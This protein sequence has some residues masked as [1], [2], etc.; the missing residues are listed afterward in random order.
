MAL[1][2]NALPWEVAP[3]TSLALRAATRHLRHQI[4]GLGRLGGQNRGMPPPYAAAMLEGLAWV[5]PGCRAALLHSLSP[6]L[7]AVARRCH[8][9]ALL[10]LLDDVA[11]ALLAPTAHSLHVDR[12][13]FPT[14][15]PERY[16]VALSAARG[17]AVFESRGAA[18]WKRQPAPL[19]ILAAA[20]TNMT[21]LRRLQL[22]HLHLDPEEM[23]GFLQGIVQGCPLL[24]DLDLKHSTVTDICLP[25]L[26]NLSH[27][28]HLNLN[29]TSLTIH[30]VQELL[31]G[32][33]AFRRLE[34][35]VYKVTDGSSCSSYS[36]GCGGS[37]LCS[38]RQCDGLV[39][40]CSRGLID[41]QVSAILSLQHQHSPP[42]LPRTSY[43][44]T[45]SPGVGVAAVAGVVCAACPGLERVAV[46]GCPAVSL[47]PLLQELEALKDLRAV[48]LCGLEWCVF[49]AHVAVNDEPMPLSRQVKEITL[50]ETSQVDGAHLGALGICFPRVTHLR[51]T[52]RRGRGAVL[53][54][55]GGRVFSDLLCLEYEG[56]LCVG[57]FGRWQ[58][59]QGLHSQLDV[60]LG[61]CEGLRSLTLYTTTSEEPTLISALRHNHLRHLEELRI[62]VTGGGGAALTC[63]TI[64]AVLRGATDLRVLGRVD[65]WKGVARGDRRALLVELRRRFRRL[66]GKHPNLFGFFDKMKLLVVVAV[67]VVVASRQC[68]SQTAEVNTTVTAGGNEVTVLGQ[69]LLDPKT[70]RVTFQDAS[71]GHTG[72]H[73]TT[74]AGHSTPG[75]GG[76][77]KATSTTQRGH[78]GNNGAEE[79]AADKPAAEEDKPEEKENKRE[80]QEKPQG[81]QTGKDENKQENQQNQQKQTNKE[82][83]KQENKQDQTE[84][85]EGKSARDEGVTQSDPTASRGH[86][87]SFTGHP[88][89]HG[90][91]SHGFG[92]HGA[93]PGHIHGFGGHSLGGHS[94][95]L[96]FHSLEVGL[97]APATLG[98][99]PGLVTS[100]FAFGGHSL[101]FGFHPGHTQVTG[102]H[103]GSF[104]G[105]GSSFGGHFGHQARSQ[106]AGV[107]A[108]TTTTTTAK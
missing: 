96:G 80:N 26:Q 74:E 20:L 88:A 17:L 2:G 16:L 82:G 71:R 18:L 25:P 63:G 86:T 24:A 92:G 76:G 84:K 57:D 27:L 53:P 103:L 95:F 77:H 32:A 8:S 104:P 52:A 90:G 15:R 105:L 64:R 3:L 100:P 35:I 33:T 5:P 93:I 42:P 68:Y 22:R 106:G 12:Y 83:N 69:L 79:E 61:W 10:D 9:E 29:L 45:G 48:Y 41:L 108:T 7:E 30:G 94:P 91:H 101:E 21:R 44:L 107:T 14:R 11:L 23:G 62:G 89:P 36:G 46:W 4:R 60:L 87:Q 6:A 40:Q 102:G 97:H 43:T 13:S 66:E 72:G 37:D 73:S 28:T 59:Q 81:K 75:H 98:H 19:T 34:A 39:A 51:V 55:D 85:P 50:S 99:A 56:D 67:V 70:G 65:W 78:S 49:S 54:W 1:C 31:K 47:K 38:A 58:R